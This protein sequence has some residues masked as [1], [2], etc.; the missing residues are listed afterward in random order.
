MSGR[1]PIER[2]SPSDV[3][4]PTPAIAITIHQREMLPA[5]EITASAIIPVECRA[6]N[7]TNTAR[8]HGTRTWAVSLLPTCRKPQEPRG[9]AGDTRSPGVEDAAE[10]ALC[11]RRM[12]AGTRRARLPHRDR[13][14][15][16]R[17]STI[18][19]NASAAFSV[20]TLPAM[21]VISPP[22]QEDHH[23]FSILL[24]C[25]SQIHPIALH[26]CPPELV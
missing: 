26:V 18:V 2:K 21:Q 24:P 6:A 11:V 25:H 22:N 4:R 19:S 20:A 7:A 9:A 8:N 16:S 5:L 1:K 23:R 14:K 17:K 13:R 3:L 12:E 10:R 15:D